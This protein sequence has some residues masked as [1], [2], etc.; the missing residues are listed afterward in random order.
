MT[1]PSPLWFASR[2][3]GLVLLAVLSATVLLGILTSRRWGTREWP[4][5]VTAGLHRNLALL[6][7]TLLPL[8]GLANVIDS[9]AGLGLRDVLVPFATSY[10]PLWLGMG[11]LAGELLV[12]LLVTSLL[13]HRLGLRLWRLTHWAA[14]ASWPLAVL[15]GLGTGS[16]TRFS[17]ALVV[18]AVC[19]G[20]V[21]LAI[22]LRLSFGRDSL[23]G[24]QVVAGA[25]T[26][27]GVLAAAVFTLLGPLQPGWAQAA[28]TPVSLLGN[29]QASAPTPSPGPV[30]AGPAGASA[31]S[32]AGGAAAPTPSPAMLA[33]LPAGIDDPLRGRAV[34]GPDGIE[35]TLIDLRDRTLQV[36]VV[37]AGDTAATGP[38]QVL[39]DGRVICSTQAVLDQNIRATCGGTSVTVTLGLGSGADGS[40]RITGELATS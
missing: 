23:R 11:V 33:A 13:R 16:D 38:F 27:G 35:V 10:R 1:E 3:L 31:S 17:W 34:R 4:R 30:A 28:G 15:H 6:G 26:L 21:A 40:G 36:E 25:A 32:G 29:R 7:V 5:F 14:Y 24:W 19:V 37:I 20:S 39:K 2:A 9:Y 8:H 12:A 18:Y 22:L